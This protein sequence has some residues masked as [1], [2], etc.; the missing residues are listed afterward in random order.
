MERR[1]EFDSQ[2][3]EEMGCLRG[4]SGEGGNGEAGEMFVD[5]GSREKHEQRRKVEVVG[6]GV[7]AGVVETELGA[8]AAVAALDRR[9]RRRQGGRWHV[10]LRQWRRWR[11]RR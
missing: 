4:E 7:N 6:T 11:R 8:A 1:G 9:R 2:G 10:V 5:G 3:E